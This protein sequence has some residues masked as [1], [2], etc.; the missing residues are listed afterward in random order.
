M[1][2]NAV[3][4]A[5]WIVVVSHLAMWLA[6]GVTTMIWQLLVGCVVM[7]HAPALLLSPVLLLRA[8]TRIEAP[9]PPWRWFDVAMQVAVLAN[10]ALLWNWLLENG[11]AGWE[12]W[13]GLGVAWMGVVAVGTLLMI[14]GGRRC[15]RPMTFRYPPGGTTPVRGGRGG[16][17]RSC[18][19]L[20]WRRPGWPERR[21]RELRSG[22]GA[23]WTPSSRPPA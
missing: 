5:G 15:V 19:A 12:T 9:H 18:Q 13:F 16:S 22:R 11:A 7:L 23:R 8:W 17:V 2:H 4:A 14:A 1:R 10:A 20:R 6:L 21:R 3:V